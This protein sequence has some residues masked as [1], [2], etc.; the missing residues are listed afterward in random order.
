MIRLEN[1][2]DDVNSV[3]G[4]YHEIG[5]NDYLAAIYLSTWSGMTTEDDV[6]FPTDSLHQHESE[7]TDSGE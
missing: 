2:P 7:C 6:P 5:G 3:L 4:D 1:T